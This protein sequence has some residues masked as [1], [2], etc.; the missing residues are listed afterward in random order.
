MSVLAL[1]AFAALGARPASA[2]SVL[3]LSFDKVETAPG[4]WH[5]TATGPISGPIVVTLDSLDT[6]GAVWHIAVDW[7]IDAGS[8]SFTSHLA[9]VLDPSTG[10]IVLNG[11]VGSGYLSGA[12]THLTAAV[13]DPADFEIAGT[14]QIAPNSA[15]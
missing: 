11:Q 9:G 10:S 2:A 5:G 4:I 7:S 1:A 12:Q 3:R 15:S 13:V 8:E 6:T 14:L